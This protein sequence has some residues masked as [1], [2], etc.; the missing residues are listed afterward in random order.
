MSTTYTMTVSLRDSV[1]CW[2]E[3]TDAFGPMLKPGTVLSVEYNGE[4]V[5][6]NRNGMQFYI[7]A[8]EDKGKV[9]RFEVRADSVELR[10]KEC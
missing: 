2:P 10:E 7:V 5:T 4:I 1:A 6:N 9:R 8:F 3:G